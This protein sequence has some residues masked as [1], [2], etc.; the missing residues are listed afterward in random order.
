MCCVLLYCVLLCFVQKCC[1]CD[2]LVVPQVEA[3]IGL[4]C[5]DAIPAS[6][7][8]GVGIKEILEVRR[9]NFT[10]RLY[11]PIDRP[12]DHNT[13]LPNCQIADRRNTRSTEGA[14]DV[15]M[16]RKINQPKTEL[17]TDQQKNQPIEIWDYRHIYYNGGRQEQ[18][19]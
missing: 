3:T 19:K 2:A 14:K 7:K 16:T 9:G 15:N 13:E 10:D 8:T 12:T 17:S 6:A 4:D 5:T 18:P 1:F 11:R